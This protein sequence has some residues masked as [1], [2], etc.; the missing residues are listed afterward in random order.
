MRERGVF[1]KKMKLITSEKDPNFLST[2][3]R[4]RLASVGTLKPHK[5]HVCDPKLCHPKSEMDFA[6][7][8]KLQG[9][10][11]SYNVYICDYGSIH[12]CSEESCR[13]FGSNPTL[14][15]PISGQQ[16]GSIVS[17]YAK[18]DY[19]TW[20]NKRNEAMEP[21]G[22][23]GAGVKKRKKK[24]TAATHSESFVKNIA[25]T[26]IINLLYSNARKEH[27]Q[28]TVL[29][30]TEEAYLAMN[31]YATARKKENQ[32][33]YTTDLYRIYAHYMNQFIPLVEMK[34]DTNVVRYY[35]EIV[36]QVWQ[37]CLKYHIHPN[38]RV[39]NEHGDEIKNR[40][41]V[42]VVVLGVLYYLRQGLSVTDIPVLP[43]DDFMENL[44]LVNNYTLFNIDKTKVTRGLNV[45]LQS[46]NN[47]VD[48][49]IDAKDLLLDITKLPTL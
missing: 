27:N 49:G 40:L 43:K 11:E 42:D 6:K 45:I 2:Y 39:F 18:D 15:C 48:V 33:A 20:Y 17:N 31:T 30:Y 13:L 5:G 28:A 7:M 38:Q 32:M 1:K 25:E 3:N 8:G 12:I 22:P 37:I 26:I 41:A 19:R 46:Y 35:C 34:L 23:I 16:M 47:A 36:W 44:P 14:T 10:P 21:S 24:N 4:L 29:K 9:T